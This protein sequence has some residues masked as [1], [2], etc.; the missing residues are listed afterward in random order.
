MEQRSFNQV[1]AF[2]EIT[3]PVILLTIKRSNPVNVGLFFCFVSC[4]P[5]LKG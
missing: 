5:I 1:R 2:I 4:R 3:L